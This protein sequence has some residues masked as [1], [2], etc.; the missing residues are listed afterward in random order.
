M[1]DVSAFPRPET[2]LRAAAAETAASVTRLARLIEGLNGAVQCARHE[3][4]SDEEIAA[5]FSAL[6]AASAKVRA[7]L[8][9]DGDGAAMRLLI[10]SLVAVPDGPF[11][12][13]GRGIPE[14]VI[15]PMGWG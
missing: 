12:R 4:L 13:G 5:H 6:P 15:V 2:G 10:A 11:P 1:N 7:A 9:A 14:R 3:G 8:A